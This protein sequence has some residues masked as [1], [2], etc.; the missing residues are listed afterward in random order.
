M[1]IKT[2]DSINAVLPPLQAG[3]AYNATIT[4]YTDEAQ[5]VL[6]NLTGYTFTLKAKEVFTD[7]SYL[8]NKALS[9]SGAGGIVTIALTDVETDFVAQSLLF[10]IIA[11]KSGQVE[12]FVR[13]TIPVVREL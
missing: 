10:D 3:K 7:T 8:I 12:P 4:V 6:K 5:S 1:A 9:H 13:G 11:V 2:Y